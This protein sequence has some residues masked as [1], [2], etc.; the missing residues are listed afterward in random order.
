MATTHHDLVRL[1]T[2]MALAVNEYNSHITHNVD[3][4]VSLTVLYLAKLKE[5]VK[6]G[7]VDEHDTSDYYS[8]VGKV[9]S[10]VD[11]SVYSG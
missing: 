7:A 2:E 10:A 11:A 5:A 3:S 9:W 8:I 1:S 6:E 4:I